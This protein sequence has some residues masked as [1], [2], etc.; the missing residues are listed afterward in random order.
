MSFDKET[1]AKLDYQARR[2]AHAKAN[3]NKREMEL[4]QRRVD[5]ILD[6]R[7]SPV[8]TAEDGEVIFDN[9]SPWVQAQVVG[10]GIPGLPTVVNAT[11]EPERV[12][13]AEQLQQAVMNEAWRI[14]GIPEGKR[15]P[16]DDGLV[17]V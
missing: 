2:M 10:T 16:E 17:G 5:T 9:A 11:G 7:P 3:G 15:P 8:G 4:I 12:C 14:L 1:Q 13:S 6:N